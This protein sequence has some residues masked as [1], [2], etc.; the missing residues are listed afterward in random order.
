MYNLYSQTENQDDYNVL[1]GYRSGYVTATGV[2][3]FFIGGFAGQQ[4]Q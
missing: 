1:I 3:N 4:H 2:F